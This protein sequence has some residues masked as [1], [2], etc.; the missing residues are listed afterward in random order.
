MSQGNHIWIQELSPY[1]IERPLMHRKRIK[2]Q[3]LVPRMG[4]GGLA[5]H[6]M[7]IYIFREYLVVQTVEIG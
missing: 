5:Y 4:V 2:A 3:Y 1:W 6:D 7:Y